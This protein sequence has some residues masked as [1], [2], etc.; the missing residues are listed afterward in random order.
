MELFATGISGLDDIL[1]GG[2]ARHHL[3]LI[4]GDPGTG[5]TTIALQF[6]LEGA[7]HG[8]KGLYVT[9][10][11]SKIELVEIAES[12]GWSLG[13]LTSLRWLRT[14]TIL[15]PR[16][17]TPFSIPLKSSLRTPRRPSFPRSIG[18]NRYAS[19]L[20]PCRNC[21]YLPAIPCAIADRFSA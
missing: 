1:G 17:S 6:L 12:H 15:N 19:C 10:S 7:R 20:I 8:Q 13:L 5:K 11:E 9:L 3:Y 2:L 16:P 21:A 18:C 4:E 14:R